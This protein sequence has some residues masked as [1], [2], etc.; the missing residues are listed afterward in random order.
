MRAG[1]SGAGACARCCAAGGAG[2]GQ[3]AARWAS[4]LHPRGTHARGKGGQVRLVR[5][6]VQPPRSG[7]PGGRRPEGGRQQARAARMYDGQWAC[8][9]GLTAFVELVP[10][11][12]TWFTNTLYC[13]AGAAGRQGGTVAGCPSEI[14]STSLTGGRVAPSGSARCGR[15]PAS[16][17]RAPSRRWPHLA[18]PVP[19]VLA[20]L[21]ASPTWYVSGSN[22]WMSVEAGPAGPLGTGVNPV[23]RC[24]KRVHSCH[25][26][27]VSRCAGGGGGRGGAGGAGGAGG[28]WG[29]SGGCRRGGGGRGGGGRGGG[30]RGAGGLG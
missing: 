2:V 20:P 3:R 13:R 28:G 21:P 9:R 12:T 27:S 7:A 18:E 17:K 10:P 11:G 5:L 30:G 1:G 6:A 15:A 22:F 26:T 23:L 16:A 8:T 4:G 29:G 25:A 19:L 24:R 14:P